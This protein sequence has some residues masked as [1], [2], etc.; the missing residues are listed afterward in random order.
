MDKRKSNVLLAA[1]VSFVYYKGLINYESIPEG[2][3][4]NK[5]KKLTFKF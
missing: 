3:T 5:N 1:A 2:V 4:V